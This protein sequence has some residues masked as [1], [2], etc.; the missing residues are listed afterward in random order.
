MD[1]RESASRRLASLALP[2]RIGFALPGG[3]P[4]K[5]PPETDGAGTP[6]THPRGRGVATRTTT[7]T[8]PRGRPSAPE[9]KIGRTCVQ[10]ERHRRH[11]TLH[12]TGVVSSIFYYDFFLQILFWY[13]PE[14]RRK[15]FLLWFFA[16]SRVESSTARK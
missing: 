15:P 2:E 8:R 14:T 16:V 5:D 13:V 7:A 1:A 11:R 3:F 10:I 6:V 4:R 9:G 12:T